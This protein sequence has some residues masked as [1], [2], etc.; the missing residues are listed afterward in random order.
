MSA[1]GGG[2][3]AELDLDRLLVKGELSTDRILFSES[4]GRFLVTV[5]SEDQTRF[6]DMMSGQPAVLA[7]RVREDT[8]LTLAAK[9]REIL[10]TDVEDLRAAFKR[11]FGKL[12]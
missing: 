5:R 6:E 8:V 9:G 4:T 2:L 3:G 11:P 7:G 10:R 12:I 1:F